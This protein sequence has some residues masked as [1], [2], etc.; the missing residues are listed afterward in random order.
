MGLFFGSKKEA[1]PEAAEPEE[2]PTLSTVQIFGPQGLVDTFAL[3][4]DDD[5]SV[6]VD[7]TSVSGCTAEGKEVVV[8]GLGGGFIAIIKQ[9]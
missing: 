3:V 1:E 9:N 2:V 5:N 6:S 7:E 4:E 8:T